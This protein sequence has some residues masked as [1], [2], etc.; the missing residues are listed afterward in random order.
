LA[1]GWARDCIASRDSLG[2]MTPPQV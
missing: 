2:E 1:N